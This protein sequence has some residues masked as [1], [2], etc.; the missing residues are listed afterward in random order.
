M[1]VT[2]DALDCIADPGSIPGISTKEAHSYASGK[3]V[4]KA[5]GSDRADVLPV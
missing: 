1:A 4:Q 2:K 3:R 5:T